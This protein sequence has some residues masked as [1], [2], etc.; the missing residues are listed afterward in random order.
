MNDT[1]PE[2][3]QTQLRIVQCAILM[4]VVIVFVV[5]RCSE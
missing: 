2:P 1:G 5:T 3:N 4:I